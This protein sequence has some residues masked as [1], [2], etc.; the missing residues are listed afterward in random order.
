ML[1]LLET[2]RELE[3]LRHQSYSVTDACRL[4]RSSLDDTTSVQAPTGDW[5]HAQCLRSL[6]ELPNTPPKCQH[7]GALVGVSI[8]I[9]A[10]AVNSCVKCGAPEPVESVI[11]MG[12]G[13]PLYPW[14]EVRNC[15]GMM[16]LNC[17]LRRQP[18]V[19][20]AVLG[21]LFVLMALVV[22]FQVGL[23]TGH[24][25]TKPRFFFSIAVRFSAIGFFV[26]VLGAAPVW[27]G[28]WIIDQMRAWRWT[29]K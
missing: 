16:H 21:T 15:G 10:I 14:Q 12:C 2:I 29:R 13:L 28:I 25:A 19:P 1:S 9:N 11:C 8:N 18:I 24:H 20:G 4:C 7:C 27:F 6:L 26:G 22:L 5:F 17:F 3:A 23:A